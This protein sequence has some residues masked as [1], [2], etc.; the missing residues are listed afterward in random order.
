MLPIAE[1]PV[2]K[3]GHILHHQ[4]VVNVPPNLAPPVL[5]LAV[6]VTPPLQT[7]TTPV[8]TNVT[9]APHPHPAADL[10]DC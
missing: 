2:Q 1:L 5:P 10:E 9:P 7:V 6:P 8:I 3:A 4:D